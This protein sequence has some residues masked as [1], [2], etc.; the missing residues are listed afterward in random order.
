MR[1]RR[2]KELTDWEGHTVN[3]R[4]IC[5]ILKD[6]EWNRTKS[7]KQNFK[8]LVSLY[9]TGVPRNNS[10]GKE[11]SFKLMGQLDI[12]MKKNEVRPPTSQY[13]KKKLT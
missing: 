10:M 1:K 7:P 5:A 11:Q 8:L 12:H 6:M 4:A 2:D 9:S 13:V 3:C